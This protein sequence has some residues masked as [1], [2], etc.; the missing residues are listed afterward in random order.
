MAVSE[1]LI[2]TPAAIT[3]WGR[4]FTGAYEATPQFVESLVREFDA[5]PLGYEP[6]RVLAVYYDNPEEVAPAELR[7]FQGLFVADDTPGH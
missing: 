1:P 3:A 6:S 2:T 7:C 5:I 4:V